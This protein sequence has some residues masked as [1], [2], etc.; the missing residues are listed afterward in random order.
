[1]EEN[2]DVFETVHRHGNVITVFG[3]PAPK[4]N[5]MY[6]MKIALGFAQIVSSLLL[7]LDLSWYALFLDQRAHQ[8]V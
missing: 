2:Y 6:K 4:A 1:M 8:L 5:F 3:A 7:S